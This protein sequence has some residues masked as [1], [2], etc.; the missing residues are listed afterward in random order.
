MTLLML[1]LLIA[2]AP[3]TISAET[4]IVAAPKESD[5]PASFHIQ[6]YPEGAELLRKT[7]HFTKASLYFLKL[8]T[9]DEQRT[10][11][12]AQWVDACK[13]T[14]S[15]MNTLHHQSNFWL[16]QASSLPA[17]GI[18]LSGQVWDE[19]AHLATTVHAQE[20]FLAS[21]F[22]KKYLDLIAHTESEILKTQKESFIRSRIRTYI[23]PSRW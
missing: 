6:Q 3:V 17:K 18:T 21:V 4:P 13:K 9:D 22:K 8:I 2:P 5:I 10:S 23:S 11:E 15:L 19:L 1:L 14:Y 16:T 7:T 20:N 12:S